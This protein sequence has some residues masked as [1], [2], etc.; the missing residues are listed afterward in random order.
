MG[1]TSKKLPYNSLGYQINAEFYADCK[2]IEIIAKLFA[3]NVCKTVI[4]VGKLP[5]FGFFPHFKDP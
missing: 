3:N 5:F 4:D 1:F 2:S